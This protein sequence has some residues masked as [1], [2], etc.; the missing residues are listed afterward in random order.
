[1]VQVQPPIPMCS[2]SSGSTYSHVTLDYFSLLV[3]SYS[4]LVPVLFCSYMTL[5]CQ[6]GEIG[7][8]VASGDGQVKHRMQVSLLLVP[9]SLVFS[10]VFLEGTALSALLLLVPFSLVFSLIFPEGTALSALLLLVPFS[11]VFSLVFPEGTVLSALLT[12]N[13]VLLTK[14]ITISLSILPTSLTKTRGWLEWG[15][16]WKP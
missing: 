3:F 6:R 13:S 14:Q 12:M 4:Q 2:G 11:L 16:G 15:R 1:M 8:H 9:F 10:L 5:L 7:K